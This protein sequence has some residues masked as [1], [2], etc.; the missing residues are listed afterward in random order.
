M[1]HAALLPLGPGLTLAEARKCIEIVLFYFAPLFYLT[2]HEI[3]T[4]SHM[5]M[6]KQNSGGRHRQWKLG[7]GVSMCPP[8]PEP[9]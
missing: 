1:L 4:Q 7:G 2:V 3:V 9:C 6:F 5:L 8:D